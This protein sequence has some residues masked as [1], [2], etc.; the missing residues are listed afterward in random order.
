VVKASEVAYREIIAGSDLY[1]AGENREVIWE[2][3]D[4]TN[5]K[6]HYEF[7]P[8]VHPTGAAAITLGTVAYDAVG[9]ATYTPTKEG[10]F[11]SEAGVLIAA[12]EEVEDIA[13]ALLTDYYYH[14]TDELETYE[15]HRVLTISA[16]D[17]LWL[18]RRCSKY[19][20]KASTAITANDIVISST[21]V[22]GEVEAAGA[23]N[24]AGTIAQYNTSLF[25]NLLGDA[26][27][28]AFGMGLASETI[29]AAGF[30]DLELLLPPRL[31][32]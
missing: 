5:T 8:Y 7:T 9:N 24:T 11:L 4:S 25:K 20:A 21:T 1:A 14:V 23:I 30:F 18:V 29:G 2:L 19:E 10:L 32:R 3:K 15:A 12:T 6:I 27:P 13:G 31:L 16:G 17:F 28:R 22:A 26:N